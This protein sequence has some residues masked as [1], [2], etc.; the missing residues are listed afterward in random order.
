MNKYEKITLTLL[1][2][3]FVFSAYGSAY[4]V[5]QVSQEEE[6]CPILFYAIKDQNAQ[7]VRDLL[8]MIKEDTNASLEGCRGDE[9][10]DSLPKDSTLLHVAAHLRGSYISQ[11]L[12]THRANEEATDENGDTPQ[13]IKNMMR[14]ERS[15]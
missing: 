3:G 14:S 9:F 8:E 11:L 10:Y 1:I 5:E 15:R 4:Q 2:F 12:I 6:S 7:I 13:D